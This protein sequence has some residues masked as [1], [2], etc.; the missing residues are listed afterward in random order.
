MN[1]NQENQ[2]WLFQA[3]RTPVL[4]GGCDLIDQ[5]GT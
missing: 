5:P 3:R 4:P 2:S 1:Q